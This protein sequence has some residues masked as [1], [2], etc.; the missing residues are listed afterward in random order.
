[1]KRFRAWIRKYSEDLLFVA[2]LL[3]ILIGTY[4]IEPLAAWFVGGMECLVAGFV[5]AWSK[6]K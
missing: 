1:M 3:A 6:R 4:K 5:L 2:G